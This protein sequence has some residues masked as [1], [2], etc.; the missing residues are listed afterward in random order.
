LLQRQAVVASI[1]NVDTLR[2]VMTMQ[3]TLKKWG[4]SPSVRIPAAIMKAARLQVNAKVDVREENGRI[5]IE[6]VRE[7]NLADLVAGI[8]PDNLHDEVNFGAAV[9]NEAL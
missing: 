4:N 7:D 9:G 1:D 6:P 2:E 8:T 5:I 3:V